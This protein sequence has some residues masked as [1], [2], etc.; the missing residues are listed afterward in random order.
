MADVVWR[1]ELCCCGATLTMPA[2]MTLWSVPMRLH[3]QSDQHRLWQARRPPWRAYPRIYEEH[4]TASLLTL[5]GLRRPVAGHLTSVGASGRS[6]V[7]VGTKPF[8][9]A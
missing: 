3:V 4:L 7:S 1:T 6:N 5:G 8:G 2:R 9:P